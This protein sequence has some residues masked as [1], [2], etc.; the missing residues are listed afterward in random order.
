LLENEACSIHPDLPLSCREQLVT[1]PAQAYSSPDR[2]QIAVVDDAPQV[3][4]LLYR[5]G[6]G[7]GKTMVRWVPPVFA[8][9]A[10]ERFRYVAER[11]LPASS[12]RKRSYGTSGRLVLPKDDRKR[13]SPYGC[14]SSWPVLNT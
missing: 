7:K 14:G 12:S 8:L 5:L 9:E 4:E 1:L 10:V 13:R 2:E 11:N 6:D 3:L